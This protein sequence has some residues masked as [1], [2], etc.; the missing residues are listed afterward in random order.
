MKKNFILG[1]VM[2]TAGLSACM[3]G[4]TREK[5]IN[6]DL[7]PSVK[8]A[9]TPPMG[10]NSFD[11]YGV[12]LHEKAAMENLEAMATKLKPFG[13][14]YFVID[15]GWFGEYELAEGS[16]CSVEKHASDVNINE[17]GIL[18]PSNTYFP[19][20]I[21]RIADRAHE[22]GLKFGVHLMRG[23]PKK[24]YQLNTPIKGTNY[25]ARDIAD[26]VN[27]CNW[28]GYNYG[29]DMS[30]P[31]AQE[32]YNSLVDQMAEWGVD[33]LKVD[34]IV[35]F[36]KEVEG[37]AKA[38][39]QASRPIVLSLSPGGNVDEDA[40]GF[41]KQGN[42]LRVTHDIWDDQ[43]GID[44]CFEAWKKWGG[45]EA[46]GFWIDMDMIPFGELQIMSPKPESL[47]LSHQE[48]KQV[49]AKGEMNNVA[50]LSGKGWHRQSEFTKDQMYTFITMRALA[51]SPL[52]MGGN[53]PT[54]DDFSFQ[55]IT[56]AEVLACNQN[57]VMGT[58][59]YEKDAIEM[60]VTPAK[61][62]DVAWVGIFNRS[63]SDKTFVPSQ[64]FEAAK[65]TLT[66]KS[67]FD[68][69]A[70][71]NFK[72]SDEATVGPNGVVFLTIKS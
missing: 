11:S 38:V 63:D 7:P 1:I 36:P 37:I 15:N 13:Y 35:P 16:I 51:A 60:W 20:G 62:N 8:L 32:F 21:K 44:Q 57:G 46:S 66:N 28:C 42:M 47:S 27:I 72:V 3:S 71:Q 59:K 61:D 2:A 33:F 53:L 23:I 9:Q 45:K 6:T 69:W 52:M 55:L 39:A 54:L 17:Y 18:Q 22:L 70:N 30:K 64:I 14:E 65:I 24:A 19:N 49:K 50:L 5:N 68:I 31:G 10:W 25:T 12:Y 41:F 48:L 40:L 43:L 34:D 4:Q 58:L 67:V 56:N 29:V 26:T